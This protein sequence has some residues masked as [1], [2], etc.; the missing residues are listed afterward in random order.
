MLLLAI[1]TIICVINSPSTTSTVCL[2]AIGLYCAIKEPSLKVGADID[3]SK[4]INFIIEVFYYV[5]PYAMW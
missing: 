4:D 3:L 1:G 5:I 2:H